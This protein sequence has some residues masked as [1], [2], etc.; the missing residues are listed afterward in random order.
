MRAGEK[1]VLQCTRARARRD[2]IILYYYGTTTLLNVYKLLFVTAPLAF[3]TIFSVLG[4]VLRRMRN[5]ATV[6]FI[7]QRRRPSKYDMR[8][9]HRSKIGREHNVTAPRKI[10]I[11]K[12]WG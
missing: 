10:S 5:I 4:H 1:H 7:L 9:A 12:R 8:R 6:Q 11:A 3:K 2:L